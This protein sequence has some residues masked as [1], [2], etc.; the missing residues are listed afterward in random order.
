VAAEALGLPLERPLTVTGGL[1]YAGGPFNSY[2]LHA[3]ATVIERLR[4]DP[5][6]PALVSSVGG[7]AS[8]HAFGIYT[9]EPPNGGF[10][11]ADL[12]A[13]ARLLPRRENATGCD[14]DVAVETYALQY[15]D[16][17]PSHATIACLL[18]DGRRTWV[19]TEDP[20]IFAEMLSREFCGR[21]AR[22]K[23]GEIQTF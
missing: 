18:E 10:R 12:D 3:I 23:A 2:V 13:E 1:A 9:A 21:T 16:G 11:Y 6:G 4:G 5:R 14:G 19:K 7:S 20:G 22:L 8:K 17:E 15:R